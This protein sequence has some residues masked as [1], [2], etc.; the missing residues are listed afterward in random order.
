[1]TL[2]RTH[3][4]FS[5]WFEVSTGTFDGFDGVAF[6]LCIV[7]E[8]AFNA[9]VAAVPTPIA[10]EAWDGWIVHRHT[11]AMVSDS[12]T[13]VHRSPLAARNLEFE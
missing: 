13:E 11:G 2:V 10:D 6:G 8:N 4:V 9:G 5:A 12:T 7:S 3:G 1:L